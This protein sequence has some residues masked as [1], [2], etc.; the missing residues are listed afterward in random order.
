MERLT[1]SSANHSTRLEKLFFLRRPAVSIA[2]TERPSGISKR[3]SIASRVVPGI[4]E[5]MTRS[6]PASWLMSVDLPALRLPTMANWRSARRGV[7]SSPT[8]GTSS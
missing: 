5:A 1:R 3:T 4:S 8:S 6:S 2:S 7:S